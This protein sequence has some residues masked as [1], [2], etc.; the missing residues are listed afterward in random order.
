MEDLIRQFEENFNIS[1]KEY[2]EE[3][4]V[5][6]PF[7]L[8]DYFKIPNGSMFGYSLKGYDNSINRILSFKEEMV[9]KIS[10]VGA[11]SLLGAGGAN[12]LLSGYYVT[13]KIEE[14]KR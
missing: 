1:L 9:P 4:E 13:E 5:V 3:I 2:I 7:T 6:T 11:S 14:E 10:F 8:E 12:A